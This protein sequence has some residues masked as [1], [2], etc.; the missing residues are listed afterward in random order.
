MA[1]SSAKKMP[2]VEAFCSSQGS[3]LEGVWLERAKKLVAEV[4]E[5][6][7]S[8]LAEFR[9]RINLLSEQLEGL[10]GSKLLKEESFLVR[11]LFSFFLP[12]IP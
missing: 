1:A 8:K 5:E 6:R 3:S 2:T 11:F 10:S 9:E 4:P 12:S 7:A